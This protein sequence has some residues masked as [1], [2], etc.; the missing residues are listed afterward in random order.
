LVGFISPILIKKGQNQKKNPPP[1]FNAFIDIIYQKAASLLFEVSREHQGTIGRLPPKD[2]TIDTGL[3][4]L[5]VNGND[6]TLVIVNSHP[7]R[8]IQNKS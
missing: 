5:H 1:A 7:L 4:V 6:F 3:T 8:L 2:L